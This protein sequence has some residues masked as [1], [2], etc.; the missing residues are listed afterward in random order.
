MIFQPVLAQYVAE[1]QY[2]QRLAEAA[3]HRLLKGLPANRS[4]RQQGKVIFFLLLILL[5]SMF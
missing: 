1:E 3:H 2:N 4:R 5:C